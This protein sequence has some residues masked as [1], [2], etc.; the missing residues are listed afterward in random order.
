MASVLI[1]GADGFT[2]RYVAA[3]LSARGH[4]VAGLVRNGPAAEPNMY[5]CDLRE[6]DK[7]GEVID[8]VRPDW[9]VHLAAIAFVGHGDAGEIYATNVIGSRNLL[10]ALAASDKRP[11]AVLLASSANIYGAGQSG[12]PIAETAPFQPAN[13]YAVSKVA[14]EYMARLWLD[15]LPIITVRPFNYIGVGQ[16]SSFL[17]AKMADHFRRRAPVIELGNIHV[18]RDFSDVRWVADVYCRLLEVAPV[19]EI[20]NVCSGHP[21]TLTY[22]LQTMST[23]TGYDIDVQINPAFVRA[24]E[25]QSQCGDNRKLIGAIGE[26][27]TPPLPD[28]LNWL[29]SHNAAA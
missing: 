8:R 14:L 1:T 4:R 26:L 22:L 27:D 19:G 3:A 9:V 13:D 23:I 18:A 7:L 6:R 16:S 17:V 20:F 25:V 21:V 5:A 15:R 24:H 28:T 29:L 11:S 12:L 10:E 2:G